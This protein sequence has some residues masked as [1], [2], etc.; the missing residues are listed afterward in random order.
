MAPQA[1]ISRRAALGALAAAGV[2]YALLGP[3]GTRD[4][5]AKGRVQLTYWE[6][7]GGHEA[8]A[9]Q[10][11]VDAF[12]ESQSRIFVRF[13]TISLIEQKALIAI[14]GGSPP[15]VVGLYS[16]SLPLFSQ[17]GAVLPLGPRA[18]AMGMDAS[19]YAPA[20]WRLC[21]ANARPDARDTG[22]AGDDLY[23]LPNTC[24]TMA[25]YYNRRVLSE[26][27]FDPDTTPIATIEQLDALA[28]RC[29]IVDP[30][31]SGASR[32]A[33]L[34]FVQ[35]EPGWWPHVWGYHFGGSL[36]DPAQDRATTASDE[37]NVRAYEWVQGTARR[38]GVQ[39]VMGFSSGLGSYSSAQ[40]P[41]LA[42]RVAMC[43]HGP[44]LV[45]V[46]RQFD[47]EFPFGV[48]PFPTAAGV[49]IDTANPVGL[50]EADVLCIC[51]GTRHPDEAMEFLAFTQ[52]QDVVE[53]LSIAHAKPSPLA[54]RSAEYYRRHPNPWIKVHEAI[55]GSSRG[56]GYPATRVW[57]EY[58]QFFRRRF[59]RDI[60]QG[61]APVQDTLA[62]IEREAQQAIDRAAAR[63]RLRSA[64]AGMGGAT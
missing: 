8:A 60:W 50:V 27:G 40:Q 9:M 43:M 39:E 54:R 30:S 42:G 38:L 29:T 62:S 23:G 31:R 12:N 3:S 33:R 25:M 58:E 26:V 21:Q 45:N 7:W 28:D 32:Y 48:C 6:K 56:F 49:P 22:S 15:D 10:R 4:P 52:R 16:K 51:T 59:D 64:G 13:L 34:G 1:S 55:A 20:I 35:T 14:A 41:L 36:Y 47:P 2:G 5:R 24:S 57:N 46:I 11:V 61:A 37:R 18:A 63:R 53:E 17:S 19:T 44:F